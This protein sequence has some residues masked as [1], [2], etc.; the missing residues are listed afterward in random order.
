MVKEIHKDVLLVGDD[1]AATRLFLEVLAARGIRGTVAGDTRAAVER[2][3]QRAWDA[4]VVD[5][6]SP[7]SNRL[8]VVRQARQHC[9]EAPVVLLGTDASVPAAVRAMREGCRDY[10]VKPVERSAVEALCDSLLPHHTV[11]L[12]AA[13]EADSRCL[14]QI[15]GRS[16]RLFEAIAL[17]KKVAP[18]SLPVLITGE[19]GT[20]KELIAYLLHRSSQRAQC[21]YVRV[22]CAALSET[23]LESELFGHERGAF[24]GAYVQRKG[25]FERAHSG[26]LLLDEIS[27]TGPRLQAELLRVLEQQDFE[28]VGGT[29]AISVNV[30][31][32]STTNRDLAQEVLRGK[33][34]P[35]LY[36]RLCGVRLPVPPLRER[37]EDIPVLVWHF[38]NQFAREAGRRITQLDP[39][40]MELF[41]RCP[42]PG[43][44]RMLRNVVRTALVVGEGPALSLTGAPWLQREL[45]ATAGAPPLRMTLRLDDVERRTILEAMRLSGSHQ[46]RA[47]KLL[48]I[49]DRTLRNKLRRY[50]EEHPPADLPVAAA[51]P[52]AGQAEPAREAVGELEP[53]MSGGKHV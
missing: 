33:F 10:L 53:L 46:A 48:G 44:V 37:R 18:T 20:G 12:A 45:I 27:E 51:T 16:P 17:A 19:S 1:A 49:T 11:P 52:A 26:T 32:I 35:D 21:P 15:V 5:L 29:E 4:V 40:M 23:L 36:Y 47:A 41:F 24:T 7:E 25:R 38:V 3:E 8:E 34:R 28:R 39:A 9:P 22:N 31:V 13:E 14:Y 30:R 6:G 2:V 50:R 42:W 43:N